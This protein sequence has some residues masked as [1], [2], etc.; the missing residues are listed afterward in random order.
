[1]CLLSYAE[2]TNPGKDDSEHLKQILKKSDLP[3]VMAIIMAAH[4]R[5]TSTVIQSV[6]YLAM[7]LLSIDPDPTSL[8]MKD[9]NVPVRNKV[10]LF[11]LHR[12]CDFIRNMQ[13]YK[14]TDLQ[15]KMKSGFD[16]QTGDVLDID[17]DQPDDLPYVFCQGPGQSFSGLLCE[18]YFC[19][20]FNKNQDEPSSAAL[21]ILEKIVAEESKVESNKLPEGYETG[22]LDDNACIEIAS[23]GFKSH[24]FSAHAV[25]LGS[26]LQ[27]CHEHNKKP[28]GGS[29]Y[30]LLFENKFIKT[31]DKFATFKASTIDVARSLDLSSVDPFNTEALEEFD[32]LFNEDEIERIAQEYD[33]TNGETEVLFKRALGHQLSPEE[34]YTN[35]GI[36]EKIS[37]LHNPLRSL[38]NRTK[39]VV[40]VVDL[41]DENPECVTNVEFLRKKI[42][43]IRALIQI[44]KKNQIGGAREI[45][46][47]TID[48]RILLEYVERLPTIISK[49]DEREMISAKQMKG[50]IIKSNVMRMLSESV[51]RSLLN[52]NSCR[53]MSKWSQAFMPIIFFYSVLPYKGISS[54]YVRTNMYTQI[55]MSNKR[56]E[57]PSKLIELWLKNPSEVHSDPSMQEL[58]TRFLSQDKKSM[59]CTYLCRSG[60]GQGLEQTGSTFLHLCEISFRDEVLKRVIGKLSKLAQD[61]GVTLDLWYKHFDAVS[62]DDKSTYKLMSSK[63]PDNL[64]CLSI[65]KKVEAF[66]EALFCMQDSERKSVE[67]INLG[68]F[69]SEFTMRYNQYSP[70]IK[71][72]HK[73]TLVPDT[74]SP[75]RAI[76]QLYGSV[77][78]LR[79]NGASSLLTRF[80]HYLNKDFIEGVFLTRPYQQN[81]PSI[82]FNCNR[83]YCPADF[84][85]YPIFQPELMDMAGLE[86][87]NYLILNDSAAPQVMKS[88]IAYLYQSG[89]SMGPSDFASVERDSLAETLPRRVH[90]EISVGMS[91]NL[92]RARDK[93]PVSKEMLDDQL[94]PESSELSILDLLGPAPNNNVAKLKSASLLYTLGAKD[95]FKNT[96]GALYYAR[97]GAMASGKCFHIRNAT[98]DETD[99]G[100]IKGKR[101]L[102]LMI[103]LK[104]RSAGYKNYKIASNML[105]HYSIYDKCRVCYSIETF[106]ERKPGF[107][108]LK[109]RKMKTHTKSLVLKKPL[110]EILHYK[111][112]NR[113]RRVVI[114]DY[115][116][117]WE[118]MLRRLPYLRDSEIETLR[119]MNVKVTG[120]NLYKLLIELVTVTNEKNEY[121]KW[122]LIGP[123][124]SDLIST[125]FTLRQSN[126]FG[127]LVGSDIDYVKYSSKID[128]D[129]DIGLFRYAMNC[130]I[131]DM[132]LVEPDMHYQSVSRFQNFIRRLEDEKGIYLLD[133]ILETGRSGLL[134]IQDMKRLLMAQM[135]LNRAESEIQDTLYKLNHSYIVWV[136]EQK[137]SKEG[138]WQG[139]FDVMVKSGKSTLRMTGHD[140]MRGLAFQYLAEKWDPFQFYGMLDT[141][142]KLWY[143]KGLKE[144][145]TIMIRDRCRQIIKPDFGMAVMIDSDMR[146]PELRKLEPAIELIP[147][148]HAN[149]WRS[150]D[151]FFDY[152]QIDFEIGPLIRL[153][154]TTRLG[155][156]VRFAGIYNGIIPIHPAELAVIES[157]GVSYDYVVV[158][159]LT[160]A[161]YQTNTRSLE[162]LRR[163]DL[164][165]LLKMTRRQV[166][167]EE[168]IIPELEDLMNVYGYSGTYTPSALSN[169]Q[170][171]E[172]MLY[173]QLLM[174]LTRESQM[175]VPSSTTSNPPVTEE[176]FFKDFTLERAAE[177]LSDIGTGINFDDIANTFE[178]DAFVG[179]ILASHRLKP[180]V[181]VT[182]PPV[183]WGTLA[184]LHEQLLI[185][186]HLP[187]LKRAPTPELW[188]DIAVTIIFNQSKDDWKLREVN[189]ILLKFCLENIRLVETKLGDLF[190][191][192]GL[193]VEHLGDYRPDPINLMFLSMSI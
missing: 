74:R 190:L 138:K 147:L 76:S 115:E 22:L 21:S 73:S 48:M 173:D 8:L 164:S 23:G 109:S 155:R 141:L 99:K 176:S 185:A 78:E 60:M 50:E 49:Y 146:V 70:L 44:F 90:I 163:D 13:E 124:S 82:I 39:C 27:A 170:N 37:R 139:P 122:L 6:R 145:N 156:V 14:L 193:T 192:G 58:K 184:N 171:E 28:M 120:P 119:A 16:E 110:A 159:L 66:C 166:S 10:L 101:Y 103:W 47:L 35:N 24:F 86:Y 36:L 51:G 46:I 157:K 57:L 42:K 160:R 117:D 130:L 179:S 100:L 45:E 178:D 169:K 65:F 92:V 54:D 143:P 168:G 128:D 41:L 2:T 111:W 104:N 15:G 96:N 106:K 183:N 31:L 64:I 97:I 95:S 71:F 72:A 34:R 62:S 132:N 118:T 108:L 98:S 56:F 135:I 187:K 80:A 55:L 3:G 123:S 162:R 5:S 93:C 75:L 191:R 20:L 43:T 91:A 113:D 87:H 126:S 134:D 63:F 85:I 182:Q 150:A 174:D 151:Y 11:L 137:K 107:R 52:L 188:V 154:S 18:I 172:T 180:K 26:K 129:S 68:E 53:D 144:L 32:N 77:R 158:D 94:D 69:N 81:D 112:G 30:E 17:V 79:A 148:K 142:C 105:D 136:T 7:R 4:N 140:D 83:Q 84:G 114:N 116:R 152:R 59:D 89:E 125:S 133:T 186:T 38:A 149:G 25:V 167:A 165:T 102:D 19:M 121:S 177:A 40:N 189:L 175:E 67:M 33:L 12:V 181:M 131:M 29:F 9:F 88:A 1:M 153:Y 127:G 161:G 61:K